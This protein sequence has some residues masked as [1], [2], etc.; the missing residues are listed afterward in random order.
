MR[1]S[2]RIA[3]TVLL[4][5]L[6]HPATHS[7]T[8]LAQ[9]VDVSATAATGNKTVAECSIACDAVSG[10]LVLGGHSDNTPADLSMHL[11]RSE[12][13]GAH[14]ALTRL[15]SSYDNLGLSRGD[16]SVAIDD[17]GTVYMAYACVS[18]GNPYAIICA[19]SLD[20]GAS[21]EPPTI[22]VREDGRSVGDK[23]FLTLG[24][25]AAGRVLVLLVFSRN[26]AASEVP[27]LYMAISWNRG[28]T[29][30]EPILIDSSSPASYGMAATGPTLR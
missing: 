2:T 5:T 18:L 27:G 6:I 13:G 20:G 7:S 14:W 19:R 9:V 15:G 28:H 1:L 11:F 10:R 29:F 3:R 24:R 21:F 30:T 4:A 16:P 26:D 22:A 23:P 12:D 25:D 8:A 17:R